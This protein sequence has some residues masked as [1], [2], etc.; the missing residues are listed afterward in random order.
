MEQ[1][2]LYC[3]FDVKSERFFPPFVVINDAVADRRFVELLVD[4]ESVLAKHPEDYRLYSVGFFDEVTGACVAFEK[5][6]VCV[7]S[8]CGPRGRPEDVARA[9]E[10]G[11]RKFSAWLASRGLEAGTDGKV[12]MLDRG[13]I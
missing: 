3:V 5:G 11:F 10:D 8:G 6:I 12:R 9:E 7:N 4:G 13:G 2:R 1:P